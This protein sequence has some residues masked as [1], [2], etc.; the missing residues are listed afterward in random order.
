MKKHGIVAAAIAVLG[1]ST[2]SAF[3]C[4]PTVSGPGHWEWQGD[5]HVWVPAHATLA[6][7]AYWAAYARLGLYA[8]QDGSAPSR[9]RD[10]A[11]ERDER[12][13]RNQPRDLDRGLTR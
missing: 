3:A 6:P 8:L 13:A 10:V 2:G 5:G 9:M 4:A 7:N 11:G 12:D 1:V